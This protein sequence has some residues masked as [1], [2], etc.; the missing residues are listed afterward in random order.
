MTVVVYLALCFVPA[1][2]FAAAFRALEWLAKSDGRPRRRR[3][4][5]DHAETLDR[6]RQDLRRLAG[7]HRQLVD[8]D[9]PAKVS[10]LTALELAYDDTLRE[11]CRAL[12]V[13]A[14]TSAIRAAARAQTEAELMVRGFVW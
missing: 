5:E 7:Q 6:L 13:T 3:P 1:L 8:A 14:P 11:V 12:D 2:V 10:R 9:V 4:V